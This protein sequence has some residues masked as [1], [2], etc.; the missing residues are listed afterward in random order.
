MIEIILGE[1]IHPAYHP[2]Y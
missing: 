1:I 2:A